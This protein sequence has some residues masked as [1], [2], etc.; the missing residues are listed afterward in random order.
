MATD[1]GDDGGII[2]V[3]YDGRVGVE[4]VDGLLPGGGSAVDFAVAVE[5]VTKQ[6]EKNGDART[7]SWSE[8]GEGPF[9][10]F[11]DG[12]KLRGVTNLAV[13]ADMRKEG[14]R[15]GRVRGWSRWRW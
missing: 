8:S 6:V 3:G 10:E 5:L 1:H 4:A 2:C 7:N 12:A 9:V 11:E 14:R 13:P 15:R